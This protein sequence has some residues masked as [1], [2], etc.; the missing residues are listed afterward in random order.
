ML[1]SQKHN[2]SSKA[3]KRQAARRT[4]TA[5]GPAAPCGSHRSLLYNTEWAQLPRASC[6]HDRGAASLQ[7][8][9]LD[10]VCARGRCAMQWPA[11][12]AR[13]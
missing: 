1:M 13:A 11:N 9:R 4:T 3:A 2:Y 8:A 5:H 12:D 7:A 10:A 6:G